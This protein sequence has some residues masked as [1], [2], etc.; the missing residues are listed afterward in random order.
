M[1]LCDSSIPLWGRSA[2]SLRWA[3]LINSVTCFISFRSEAV[4]FAFSFFAKSGD[5]ITERAF[6]QDNVA[7]AGGSALAGA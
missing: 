3:F 5:Q 2:Y 6:H 1:L 4:R 7:N